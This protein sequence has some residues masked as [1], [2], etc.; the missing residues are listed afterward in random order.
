[1]QSARNREGKR[2]THTLGL[3]AGISEIG[4]LGLRLAHL[5]L[6]FLRDDGG[7]R[8]ELRPILEEEFRKTHLE[9]LLLL[10]LLTIAGTHRTCIEDRQT[11]IL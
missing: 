5:Q 8:Y 2:E 9:V 3:E 4:R 1:M 10:L 11:L 7:V 6:G